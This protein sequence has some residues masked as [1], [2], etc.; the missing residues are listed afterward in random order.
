MK[1]SID[2]CDSPTKGLGYCNAH[3]I[4]LRKYGDP[5]GGSPVFHGEPMKFLT[6]VALKHSSDECL[7]WPY[8]IRADGRGQVRYKGRDQIASRVV[9][10]LAHG[11]P[12]T[13]EH[14]AAHSCGKGHLGCV[15]PGHLRWA[16]MLENEHDKFIHGTTV[17]GEKSGRT[18]LTDE[19]VVEILSLRGVET[20][21]AIAERF[22]ISERTVRRVNSGAW[23]Y[24]MQEA[25]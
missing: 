25:A 15:A 2:G 10:E 9:C 5:M 21:A 20:Q 3:Y 1:C 19:K 12:P 17:R 8:Y 11:E 22:N 18:T 14:E 7:R 23:V 6:E 16:T 4:R 13:P 24:R